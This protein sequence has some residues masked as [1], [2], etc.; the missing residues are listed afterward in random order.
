MFHAKL[1]Y[2]AM[3]EEER[4]SSCVGCGACLKKCP[5]SIAIPTFMKQIAG[6]FK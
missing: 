1:V 3:R 4:A 5:Q 2:D 6:E